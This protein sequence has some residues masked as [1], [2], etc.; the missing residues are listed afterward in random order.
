MCDQKQETVKQK[1]FHIQHSPAMQVRQ[2]MLHQMFHPQNHHLCCLFFLSTICSMI[3]SLFIQRMGACVIQTQ[4]STLP[5]DLMFKWQW[6]S[7]LGLLRC[8]SMQFSEWVSKF[9]GTMV[10]PSDD[11][12]TTLIR[13]VVTCLPKYMALLPRRPL[14]FKCTFF[15]VFITGTKCFY[16]GMASLSLAT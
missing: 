7:K 8:N 1:Q 14:Y 11:F 13:N 4:V 10:L 9:C 5:W 15:K 3:Y 16:W 2:Q 12:G 6:E